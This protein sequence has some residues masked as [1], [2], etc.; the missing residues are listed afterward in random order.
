MKDKT[1]N[2]FHGKMECKAKEI[3]H[4]IENTTDEIKDKMNDKK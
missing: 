1:C 3:G 2:M 4:D